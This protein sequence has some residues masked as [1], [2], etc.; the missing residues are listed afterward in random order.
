[1]T[2]ANEPTEE[3]TVV[4]IDPKTHA[5]TCTPKCITTSS[6][7]E[8]I[9]LLDRN[10]NDYHIGATVA[11]TIQNHGGTEVTSGDLDDDVN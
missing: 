2:P 10:L 8:A 6:D 4:A 5:H 11:T 1:M 3:P 7:S 9:S